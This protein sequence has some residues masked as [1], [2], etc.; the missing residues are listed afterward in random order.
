M[1]NLIPQHMKK[2]RQS[3]YRHKYWL[4]CQFGDAW[5]Y[6][7]WSKT[8]TDYLVEGRER[9]RKFFDNL[10]S[11]TLVFTTSNWQTVLDSMGASWF[12]RD[13]GIAGR[14]ADLIYVDSNFRPVRIKDVG[15]WVDQS[16]PSAVTYFYELSD[17]LDTIGVP[18]S[19]G[20]GTM[21]LNVWKNCLSQRYEL[22]TPKKAARVYKAARI[23][24]KP[25]YF[26]TINAVDWDIVGAYA[27]AMSSKPLPTIFDETTDLTI[28]EYGDGIALAYITPRDI[29]LDYAYVPIPTGY[30][31][32][33]RTNW[34]TDPVLGFFTYDDI[35]LAGDY[36]ASIKIVRNW[37][38]IEY[39]SQEDTEGMGWIFRLLRKHHYGKKIVNSIWGMMV[40]NP[41]GAIYQHLDDDRKTETALVTLKDTRRFH[42]HYASYGMG[43]V[44]AARIRRKLYEE[45]LS[46]TAVVL[47]HTDGGIIH[48]TT[49]SGGFDYTASDVFGND[50]FKPRG[51]IGEGLGNW[52][53]EGR[54]RQ[55]YMATAQHYTWKDAYGNRQFKWAGDSLPIDWKAEIDN[56]RESGHS[57]YDA[58]RAM[59]RFKP[60]NW[61]DRWI[62]EQ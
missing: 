57:S 22:H 21:G 39:I 58:I 49:V 59:F 62:V 2:N 51:T 30:R 43:A 37:P 26:T 27:W 11:D 32:N 3:S 41:G 25:A 14:G 28:G 29:N 40:V 36:G 10:P 6:C 38:A 60:E 45:L 17:L 31:K 42:R 7:H 19:A 24:E 34:G 16:F 18:I 46:K 5:V 8:E 53:Y 47:C 12:R 23:E 54:V 13:E 35:R 33:Q 4:M 9:V 1:K 56:Q 48:D 52:R 50:A 20:T 61:A 15:K 55:L 44:V